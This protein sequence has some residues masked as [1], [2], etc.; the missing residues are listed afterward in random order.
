MKRIVFIAYLII[1]FVQTSFAQGFK[2]KSLNDSNSDLSAS[3]FSRTDDDGHPCGLIKVQSKIQGLEFD[4][5]IIGDINNQVNEYWVYMSK[6]T[7]ELVIT[8]PHYLP[9]NIVLSDY[10][11][12]AIEPKHTYSLV[13][14]EENLNEEK[15]GLVLH[16]KPYEAMVNIDGIKIKASADGSYRIILPKGEHFCNISSEG[17]RTETKMVNTGKGLQNIDVQLESILA[18]IS[19]TCPNGNAEILIDGVSRGIG[20]WSGK[21]MPGKHEIQVRQQ[22]CVPATRLVSLAQKEKRVYKMPKLQPIESSIS[23][24]SQPQGCSV[25]LDGE[26]YG[27]TPCEIEAKYGEHDLIIV[28]DSCGLK[29]EVEK[30]IKVVDERTQELQFE[31]CPLDKW[32]YH[33]KA[34]RWFNEGFQFEHYG[35][36]DSHSATYE[37]REY[38]DKIVEIIDYLEPSFFFQKARYIDGDGIEFQTYGNLMITTF[39]TLWVRGKGL[40]VE[41][42]EPEKAEAILDKMGNDLDSSYLLYDIAEAYKL[43]GKAEEAIKCYSK[44]F[45]NSDCYDSE[46]CIE[47]GDIYEKGLGVGKNIGEAL[48]WYRKAEEKGHP[49]AR[50]RISQLQ[51]R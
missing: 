48:K 26:E 16:V 8:R 17:Y 2:V 11:I 5:A 42:A 20:G 49:D 51:K 13:L 12:D 30:V 22:G 29:K 35:G 33:A 46:C 37:G 23:I 1:S 14:K 3:T 9:Q 43:Q 21:I 28:L 47:I 40:D 44:I 19:I 15:C 32:N 34:Y 24:T 41:A 4:G 18:E 6:G 10:G 45:E 27:V 50:D 7:K 25:Y 39:T 38:Y 31:V 36:Q